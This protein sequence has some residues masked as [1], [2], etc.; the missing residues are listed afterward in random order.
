MSMLLKKCA[1]L[2]IALAVATGLYLPWYSAEAQVPPLLP[3]GGTPA[4]TI[5]CTCSATFWAFF[6]PL[7]LAAVPVVGPVTY[8]PYATI[9]FANFTPSLPLTPHNGAYLPGVQACWMYA[10]ITCVPLPSVGAMS[11]VGTGLPGGIK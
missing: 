9:P 1:A 5:P 10:G 2:S 7:F 3:F 8:V 4:F 11:F 6:T